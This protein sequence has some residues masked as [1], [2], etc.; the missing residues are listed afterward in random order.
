[1]APPLTESEARRHR[2]GQM[3]EEAEMRQLIQESRLRR[4]HGLEPE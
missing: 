2:E 3:R 4:L 1:M